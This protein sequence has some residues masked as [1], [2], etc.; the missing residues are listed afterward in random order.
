MHT[1]Q[2]FK[3]KIPLY[4][5]NRVEIGTIT[6]GEAKYHVDAG[7]MLLTTKG[8]G[9]NRRYTSARWIV[10]RYRFEDWKPRDSGGYLVWQLG[11]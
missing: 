3:E 11:R 1:E 10:L 8:R 2:D 4:S 9:R 7:E 5:I 6:V